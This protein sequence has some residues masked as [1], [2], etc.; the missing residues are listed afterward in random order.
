M[1]FSHLLGN[2]RFPV[3]HGRITRAETEDRLASMGNDGS[4]LLR[5]SETVPGAYCLCVLNQPFVHTYR[6]SETSGKWS[7]QTLK[8]VPPRYFSS[9]EQ[10]LLAYEKPDQGLVVT[11]LHPVEYTTS[12]IQNHNEDLQEE[13]AYMEMLGI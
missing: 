3:Y 7:V 8:G 11:L 2:M 6:V 12:K 13:R 9:I 4:Y 5:D 1:P 10:L